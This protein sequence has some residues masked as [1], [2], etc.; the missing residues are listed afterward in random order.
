MSDK[1][2][3]RKEPRNDDN[4]TDKELENISGGQGGTQTKPSL[5]D[6]ARRLQ[7]LNQGN[8]SQQSSKGTQG[9]VEL[10]TQQKIG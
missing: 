2:Y 5:D 1:K 10:G 6:V 3:G 8:Q 4:L 9:N 7:R